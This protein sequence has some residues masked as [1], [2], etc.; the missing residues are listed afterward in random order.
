MTN[1]FTGQAVDV[2]AFEI[3]K[4]LTAESEN[5]K[6]VH[7]ADVDAL[8]VEYVAAFQIGLLVQ[9][10]P[11]PTLRLLVGDSERN[12]IPTGACRPLRLRPDLDQ[13]IT[14]C[15][16]RI[17]VMIPEMATE[18]IATRQG[19][20]WGRIS[21]PKAAQDMANQA[22]ILPGVAYLETVGR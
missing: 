16:S 15:R 17:H 20:E 6:A 3:V 13:G 4:F 12:R 2:D 7:Y 5:R 21:H 11:A 1:Q 10:T 9:G 14:Y 18:E 8:A 19:P 22:A